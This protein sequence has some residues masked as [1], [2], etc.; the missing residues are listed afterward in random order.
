M[1]RVVKGVVPGDE[2]GMALVTALLILAALTLLAVT[3]ITNGSID[4]M[5]AGNDYQ[6]GQRF[7]AGEGVAEVAYASLPGMVSGVRLKVKDGEGCDSYRRFR[8][9]KDL[10]RYQSGDMTPVLDAYLSEKAG[11]NLHALFPSDSYRVRILDPDDSDGKFNLQAGVSGKNGDQELVR[12]TVCRIADLFKGTVN[13][14]NPDRTGDTTYSFVRIVFGDDKDRGSGR[15]GAGRMKISGEESKEDIVTTDT[16][17]ITGPKSDPDLSTFN[18]L[19]YTSRSSWEDQ[20]KPGIV[21]LPR[22]YAPGM[23][24]LAGFVDQLKG[25]RNHPDASKK[26]IRIHGDDVKL[27]GTRDHPRVTWLKGNVV[28]DGSHGYGVLIIEDYGDREG[29]PESV[30]CGLTMKGNAKFNG[31]VILL[32]RG[33]R[34]KKRLKI[35]FQ[36]R[37]SLEGALIAASSYQDQGDPARG[38]IRFSIRDRARCV[39][40]ESAVLNVF[41]S[42]FYV[43][44]W[45]YH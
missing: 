11:T 25:G 30:S 15:E 27:L 26:T 38:G 19:D 45:S 36:D 8:R 17:E 43:T 35:A 31:L 4:T 41:S 7:F 18:L 2:R 39:Y 33:D 9:V 44:G 16:M 37:A 1:G 34:F 10:L 23:D 5:I 42:P 20:K 24:D 12:L 14:L 21:Y 32:P 29:C 22:D 40:N 13:L 3:A 6:A 28:I